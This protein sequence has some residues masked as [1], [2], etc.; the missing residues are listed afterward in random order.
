MKIICTEYNLEREM[1]IGM[2]G[3]NALLRNNDDFYIPDFAGTVSCV[4]QLVTRICKLGKGIPEQFAER[5]HEDIGLCVR[6]YADGLLSDLKQRKLPYGL[7]F[8]FDDSAA[9]SKLISREEE[10]A[11][12]MEING[13][14]T[15]AGTEKTLPFCVDTLVAK[16]SDYYMLKIGD[17]LCCG[18]PYRYT[19][20]K[21]GDHIR[22]FL[23]G[24]CMMDFFIR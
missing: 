20:I 15:F 10:Q 13:K 5:Y 6:F 19:P 17:F 21:I 14:E 12:A 22:M 7:A 1:A 9:F 4:P 3:D 11:Y 8:S 16:A 24:Q 23:N 18:N 2:I